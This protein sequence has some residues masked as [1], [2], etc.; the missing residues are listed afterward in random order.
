MIALVE[1]WFG[2]DAGSN[3]GFR[4]SSVDFPE[5]SFIAGLSDNTGQRQN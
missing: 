1:S 3:P 2:V 5:R 4:Y